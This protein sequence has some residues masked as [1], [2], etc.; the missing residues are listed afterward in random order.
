M[1]AI[2]KCSKF[3]AVLLTALTIAS[4]LPMQTF[5]TEHQN[6]QTLTTIDTETNE[7]LLIK[8][9]VV[10]ERTANSKTYLLEDGTY[11]SLTTSEPIHTYTSDTWNDIA[12]VSEQPE[13]VE[14][15]MSQLSSLQTTSADTSV[16]DGFVVS[17]PDQS[18]NLYGVDVDD[19][20]TINSVTLSESTLGI[21]KYNFSSQALY[22]KNEITIKAELRLSCSNVAGG[23]TITIHPIYSDWDPSTLSL[24]DI[25]SDFNN[26]CIDYNSIDSSGRYIWDITSEYIKWENGSLNNNGMLLYTAD[27]VVTVYNGILRRHYRIVDNNDLGFTYHEVDMGRAGTMYINDY[28]NVPYLVRDELALD[29]NI[30]PASISRFI[31]P[32]LENNSFGA[33]G[34]WNYESKL[35]KTADTYIWD[36]FNGSSSRFQ[37]AIPIETDDEGREKWGEYQYNAQG[38][39]LWVNATKSRDY[40]YSDNYIVDES[41]NTY[42]FNYYGYVDSVI[43]GANENDILTIAYSGETLNSITD[44]IGRKYSFTYGTVNNQTVITKLSAFMTTTDA[45]GAITE[46]PI[47]ILTESVDSEGNP[48]SKPVE[49]TFENQIINNQVVLTKAIYTDGKSVEYTYDSFG[50]LT[51]IKNIDGSLLE[52]SYAIS[53]DNIGQNVSPIYAYRLSGYTKKCLY[54]NGQYVV[55][56][57]VSINAD[58]AYHRVFEQRNCQNE[59][60][61]SEILQFNRNLDL[62]YMTNSA[63]DAFYADYDESHNL[64]SIVI[65]DSTTTNI[66]QNPTMEKRPFGTYPKNWTK[67]T[68]LSQD[69]YD[70]LTHE[71]DNDNQYIQFENSFN[72]AIYLSQ[73]NSINGKAG[74]K[75]VI[76][77]WG[78]GSA[79]LPKEDH[80]W[81]IRIFAKNEE[82]ELIQIH[83]MALDASLW[84]VEQTRSTAFALPFDTTSITVQM[85]SDQQLGEVAFDDV[86]LYKADTAYVAT[87]DDVQESSSCT[88]LNCENSSCA[89]TCE[90]ED[91]CTCV[92]CSIKNIAGSDAH[93]NTTQE[94]RTDG[95]TSLISQYTYTA[96]SNYLSQYTDENNISTSYVY[97]LANGLKQSETLANDSSVLYGYDAVGALTSVSQTVTNFLTDSSIAMQTQY[98]YENDRIVSITHNGFSYNYDYDIYGNLS[99]ISVSNTPLV[100]Y[101]YNNDYY[102]SVNTITYA[103]GMKISYSYDAKGNITGISY[104]E[105]DTWTFTYTYDEYGN[106]Q[107][108]TDTINHT[109][110]SYDKTIN[111]VKYKEVMETIGENST[112]IYSLVETNDLSCMQSVFGQN[113][114][115]TNQ[116]SYNAAE[117]TKTEVQTTS[118]NLFGSDGFAKTTNLEDAFGRRAEE[119]IA[120]Y[121]NTDATLEQPVKS[122][123]VCNEY[124]YKNASTTR[125]TRLI[126]TYISTITLETETMGEDGNLTHSSEIVKQ[127]NL[128]YDYDEA[129]RITRISQYFNEGNFTG[130]FPISFYSYDEA[131]QLVFEANTYTNE[132]W[133]YTYDAGG[134]ILSKSR[135]GSIEVD[136]ETFELDLSTLGPPVETISYGYDSVWKD[137]LTSF[138]GVSIAYDALGNPL[139]YYGYTVSDETVQ[140]NLEWEGRILR[141]ATSKDGKN[142]YEYHYD[143]NGLRTGKTMYTKKAYSTVTQDESGNDVTVTK[144]QFVQTATIEYIWSNG[145]LV[146]YKTTAFNAVKDENNNYVFDESGNIQTEANN[147]ILV[148]PIYNKTNEIVGVSCCSNNGSDSSSETFYFAKDAQ[149]NICS[150]YSLEND[151]NLDFYYDAFGK[152]NLELGGAPV[153]QIQQAISNTSPEWAQIVIAILGATALAGII[154]ITFTCAP[155]AYRGYVFDIETGLYYCQSRYYSPAWGRFINADNTAILELTKGKTLGANL[156]AYCNNDPVN[157]ADPSGYWARAVIAGVSGAVFGGIAYAIGRAFKISGWKLAA[158]TSAFVAAGIAI[159]VIWGPKILYSINSLIKPVIYFFSNPGKV[160]FGI[161]LLSKIQFE[162]HNPHHGK[163]IHFVI[164][165][166]QNGRWKQIFEWVLK[167]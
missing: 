132:I 49:I 110:T 120:F 12:T 126:D 26:P 67:P 156:F 76:S 122:V 125:E 80:F 38:Y 106:L 131:G 100:S 31:N 52:L 157:N 27:S 36:M 151:Y 33:G 134:N 39:V 10:E 47:T 24:A 89:C 93:G 9:E 119:T 123:T 28:T 7:D 155:N 57:S 116:T 16:D 136:E 104:D 79:T 109:V 129:G 70:T 82:N 128:K 146:G 22:E 77:A 32:G 64:L 84:Q 8:E 13:T 54:E 73:E 43:S 2:K 92:S 139:N 40:D 17:A 102:K 60:V 111:G 113:Y 121:T 158:F 74:D 166:L 21:F 55:D 88:C 58:N 1:K 35:S 19:Q 96:D 61:F 85:I 78:L 45:S 91:A 141:A 25:E 165:Q 149:G 161:K 29:G 94:S 5:A 130:Y 18:I 20:V 162:L 99:S 98:A 147:I 56:F 95:L 148:K 71:E 115:V 145:V 65:P 59:I 48:I 72:G 105:G 66:I 50:R 140:V 51:K 164:R 4:I 41:G 159:G 135:Y 90:S 23:N 152:F 97:S 81:G 6:Y 114:S 150:I 143:H 46:T 118:I 160:Y 62:L 37:K 75:Y 133:S 44:G 142:R 144:E 87:V 103:N 154:G 42:T 108:Y 153:E 107:S 63:G 15:A 3:L 101:S 138:D 124:T 137:K 83:Q 69:V 86:Y 127:I 112:I 34:R 14:E 167:K 117:G 11:C 163:S 53:V 68:S 30:M